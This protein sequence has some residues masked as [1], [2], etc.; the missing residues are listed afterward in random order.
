LLSP[1]SDVVPRP[2]AG[3]AHVFRTLLHMREQQSPPEKQKVPRNPLEAALALGAAAGTDAWA[4]DRGIAAAE[5]G[6]AAVWAAAWRAALRQTTPLSLAGLARTRGTRT[7]IAAGGEG[8]TRRSA[9][10]GEGSLTGPRSAVAGAALAVLLARLAVALAVLGAHRSPAQGEGAARRDPGQTARGL[11][12]R[13]R[14]AE[15]PDEAIK[16]CGIHR[17]ALPTMRRVRHRGAGDHDVHG[18]GCVTV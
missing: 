11:A 4:G 17:A 14:L 3:S 12:A 8:G 6:V 16:L 13:P 15:A 2:P 18:A 5:R 1:P 9:G 7:C 10:A